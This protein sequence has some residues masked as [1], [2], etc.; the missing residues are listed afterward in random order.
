MRA[1]ESPHEGLKNGL[2][3][4]SEVRSPPGPI[5]GQAGP[6]EDTDNMNTNMEVHVR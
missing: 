3:T 6:T 4:G 1:R 2:E 5:R